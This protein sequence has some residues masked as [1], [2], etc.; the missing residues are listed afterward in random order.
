[1]ECE[2]DGNDTVFWQGG[3]RRSGRELTGR[4]ELMSSMIVIILLV[5]REGNT[6]PTNHQHKEGVQGC[7][8]PS[9]TIVEFIITRG[10]FTRFACRKFSFSIRF[11]D[12]TLVEIQGCSEGLYSTRCR[13]QRIAYLGYM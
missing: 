3:G 1:M 2:V 13:S 12:M 9:E 11:T 7:R 10:R 8:F 6:T 4:L 5:D